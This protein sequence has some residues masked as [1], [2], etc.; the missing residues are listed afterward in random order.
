MNPLGMS[1]GMD[2]NSMVSKIVDAERVPKQQ[3]IDSERATIETNISAYGQLRQ[4]LDTMKNLMADFRSNKAFAVRTV[5][6]TNESV[7]AATASTEAIAGRYSVDVLQL[8]QSHKIASEPFA[9]DLRFGSGKL[10]IHLG[11][12]KF[13]VDVKDKSKPIDI[14]QAVNGNKENPG[15]RASIINDKD[16]KRIVFS[17]D[18]SGEQYVMK[19]TAIADPGDPLN[20][21]TYKTLEERVADLEKA[22]Q[23]AQAA[24]ET[25]IMGQKLADYDDT[26]QKNLENLQELKRQLQEIDEQERIQQE[27][28]APEKAVNPNDENIYGS[29][30][31]SKEAKELADYVPGT[32]LDPEKIPGWSS[33]ASGTLHDSYQMREPIL[34]QKAI[35]KKG[36][37]PGWSNTASGTL[38]DSYTTPSEIRKAAREQEEFEER[39]QNV[40]DLR[41]AQAAHDFFDVRDQAVIELDDLEKSLL[42]DA[43]DQG[44]VLAE[45]AQSKGIKALPEEE[46]KKLADIKAAQ[47][48]MLA[49]EASFTTFVGMEEIQVGQDAQVVVDGVAHLSSENNVIEDAIQGVDLTLKGTTGENAATEIGVEYDQQT[50]VSEIERFVAAYNQFYQTTKDLAAVDPLTG[51][52]GPLSGDSTVRSAESRLKSVFSASIEGA[53]AEIS[54]LT[55]FG[56]TSTRQ[57]TLEINYD[58]LNK[59][60]TNNFNKLEDFFGGSKGFARKV[61]EAINSMTGAAG[62]IRTRENSMVE[63]NYRLRDTQSKLDM[64]MEALEGRTHAKFSAMQD[65]TA[66]MQGQ[67]SGMMSAL[68]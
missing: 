2:I 45:D 55:E 11:D 1:T 25:P 30:A 28:V 24:L 36:E 31:G 16:G 17:S 65:A 59:Q 35:Q 53:P 3:R 62:S 23:K 46:Q 50:V 14:V 29:G 52:A 54:S 7:V 21:L 18:R 60:V 10:Q 20:K 68:G 44:I 41:K 58:L 26:Y 37:I 8:A 61:E 22:Q 56:I 40:T 12:T 49:A 64:R 34:D 13:E 39:Q 67:L 42:A 32:G 48:E 66:K 43:I 51:K 4:S 63:Q 15:V 27:L 9:D 57:G 38:T 5:N 47:E 33:G 6:T 19:I